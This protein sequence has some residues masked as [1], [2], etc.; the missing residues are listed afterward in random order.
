MLLVF[1]TPRQALSSHPRQC[2]CAFLFYDF[3][4]DKQLFQ[5]AGAGARTADTWIATPTLPPTPWGTPF[6]NIDETTF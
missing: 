4:P 6:M 1:L 3:H 2:F 5:V